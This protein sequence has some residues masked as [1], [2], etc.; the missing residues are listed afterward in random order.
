ML[1]VRPIFLLVSETGG[2]GGWL[3]WIHLSYLGSIQY[4]KNPIPLKRNLSDRSEFARA[5]SSS[6]AEFG[7]SQPIAHG[8]GTATINYMDTVGVPPHRRSVRVA[9]MWEHA[10][11]GDERS[12][13]HLERHGAR[14]RIVRLVERLE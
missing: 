9:A 4:M 1:L 10:V 5:A 2:A 7:C 13:R 3:W 12:R 11:K 8:I 6:F 14:G